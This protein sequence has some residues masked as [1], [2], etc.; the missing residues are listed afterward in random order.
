LSESLSISG[1]HLVFF[2]APF[3]TAIS[4]PF[5]GTGFGGV[6]VFGSWEMLT[7]MVHSDESNPNNAALEWLR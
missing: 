3:S 7:D 6:A 4:T 5:A 1:I 2:S